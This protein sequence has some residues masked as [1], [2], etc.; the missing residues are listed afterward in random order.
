MSQIQLHHATFSFL[1]EVLDQ[2]AVH[3]NSEVVQEMFDEYIEAYDPGQTNSAKWVDVDYEA[4]HQWVIDNSSTPSEF[5]NKWALAASVVFFRLNSSSNGQGI[6][7]PCPGCWGS[8]S[9]QTLP[10]NTAGAA[11]YTWIYQ[12]TTQTWVRV[13]KT[14][15]SLSDPSGSP[16]ASPEIKITNQ[17][18]AVVRGQLEYAQETTSGT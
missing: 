16:L 2:D 1:L 8:T 13:C 6:P 14:V 18:V 11:G 10:L 5:Q 9:L 7:D 4:V 15:F 3:T 12:P 17:V